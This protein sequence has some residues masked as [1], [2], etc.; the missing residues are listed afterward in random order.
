MSNDN[1]GCFAF[2]LINARQGRVFRS[3]VTLQRYFRMKRET[4]RNNREKSDEDVSLQVP[5]WK[6]FRGNGLD[7]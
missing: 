6:K 2:A 3:I 1:K 5:A 4:T 7:L